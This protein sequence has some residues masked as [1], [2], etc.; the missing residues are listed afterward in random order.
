MRD[1]AATAAVPTNV[2]TDEAQSFRVGTRRVR[3]NW[4]SE[5]LILLFSTQISFYT[6][7]VRIHD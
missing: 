5:W 3:D 7:I 6:F 2:H 4:V 1:A